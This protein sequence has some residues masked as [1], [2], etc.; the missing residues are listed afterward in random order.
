MRLEVVEGKSAKFWQVHRK[1]KTVTVTYG[2][3]GTPGTVKKTKHESDYAARVFAKK[4]L[5]AKKVEG[6]QD[7]IAGPRV[8]ATAAGATN[9]QLE[10]AIVKDPADDG[11][12]LVYGD[13]LMEQGDPRGPLA[14]IKGDDKKTQTKATAMVW[15]NRPFF[16]G[17]LAIYTVEKPD[18]HAAVAAEWKQGWMSTLR[19]SAVS[20]WREGQLPSR[21]ARSWCGC[22]RR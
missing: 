1:D 19:L 15:K 7:V 6:Y 5:K 8:A 14:A 20:S 18:R 2:K 13:W 17:P 11:G 12:Y 21:I 4:Q 22:S 3:I 10:A 16:F 9:P